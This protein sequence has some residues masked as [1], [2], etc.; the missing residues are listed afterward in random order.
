MVGEEGE[1]TMKWG[2][3]EEVKVGGWTELPTTAMTKCWWWT[4]SW[5]VRRLRRQ[6]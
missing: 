3:M 2:E 1:G 6:L 5:Y 4:P